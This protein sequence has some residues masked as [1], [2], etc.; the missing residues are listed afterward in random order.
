MSGAVSRSLVALIAGLMFG[1]GL[2]LSQMVNPVRVVGFLDLAGAWDP[3]LALVMAGALAITVPAFPW[4]LKR[5][6]PVLFERFELPT[7]RDVDSRLVAGSLLFGVG[8]GI[9]GFCP[10]PA[11]AALATGQ[12]DVVVFVLA[13]FSGFALARLLERRG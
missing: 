4:I 10:G 13:M 12:M 1:A 2:A 11:L 8:W 6:K 3:T 7:R 9:G 5:P